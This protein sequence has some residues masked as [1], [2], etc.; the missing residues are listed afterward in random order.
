[1]KKISELSL[2]ELNKRKSLLKGI[3]IGFS[4]LMLLA[5]ST[6][7]YL[8]AKPILFVPVFVLPIVWMPILLS[9]KSTN[10]A[11]KKLESNR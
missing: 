10:D 8:K 3:I 2:P 11:I 1:M 7:V 9:L 6:L 4:V 5:I